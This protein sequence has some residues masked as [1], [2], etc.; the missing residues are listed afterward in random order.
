MTTITH[1]TCEY[2]SN[3]LGIDVTAPRFSWQ[4]Q[5]DRPAAR[6]TAYHIQA[7]SSLAQLEA[8][9]ADLWD[10]GKVDS[11]QSVHVAY[12]GS[13][14]GSRQ[15]VYWQ[16]TIWDESGTAVD[17][18]PAWFELGLLYRADWQAEWIGPALIGGPRTNVPAPYLRKPFSLIGPIRQARLYVTALGLYE[19][20]VNG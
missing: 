4:L 15:R 8:G 3:P 20:S 7:S 17:S 10:S 6:Q 14:L 9:Q 18:E 12:A 1:L 13:P 5:S 2:R 16:V 19:C 11:D